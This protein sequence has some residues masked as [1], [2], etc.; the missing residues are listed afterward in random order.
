MLFLPFWLTE[1]TVGG[2]AAIT[3]LMQCFDLFLLI[4]L[5]CWALGWIA[6]TAVLA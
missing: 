3:Q 6:A 4:W 5:C 1:W 2:I